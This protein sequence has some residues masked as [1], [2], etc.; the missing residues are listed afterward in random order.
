MIN[1]RKQKLLCRKPW[2]LY[3]KWNPNPNPKPADR[4]T[5]RQSTGESEL[6]TRGNRRNVRVWIWIA[7]EI[8]GVTPS[9]G[10]AGRGE[11]HLIREGNKVSHLYVTLSNW[12]KTCM[13]CSSLFL[14]CF[15]CWICSWWIII[16]L[17]G[18]WP[19]QSELRGTKFSP[20]K[21][22]LRNMKTTGLL[23]LHDKGLTC[24]PPSCLVN[25]F[26]PSSKKSSVGSKCLS[27]FTDYT[28]WLLARHIKLTEVFFLLSLVP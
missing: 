23:L 3:K 25:Q 17:S 27:W 10:W 7:G 16:L 6:K 28:G 15:L 8:S 24:C 5:D 13:S 26:M 2:R 18:L 14:C 22:M 4:Q 11:A 12:S 21:G 20:K 9:G 19:G 1:F